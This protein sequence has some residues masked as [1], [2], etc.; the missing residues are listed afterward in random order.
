[1]Y[2]ID[3]IIFIVI[4]FTIIGLL[5][6]FKKDTILYDIQ[7]VFIKKEDFSGGVS[8]AAASLASSI[9]SMLPE[10]YDL[11]DYNVNIGKNLFVGFSDSKTS[12]E[13]HELL[14]NAF[15][16]KFQDKMKDTDLSKG[17]IFI[18]GGTTKKIG[19]LCLGEGVGTCMNNIN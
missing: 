15:M 16:G 7:S 4:V 12:D 6:Y 9:T 1:M 8:A 18:N 5:I 11:S 19:S 17:N 13:Q 10:K 14:K 3:I 2:T